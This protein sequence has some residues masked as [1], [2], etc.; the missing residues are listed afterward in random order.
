ML[1]MTSPAF[2]RGHFEAFDRMDRCLHVAGWMLNPTTP[3]ERFEAAIN[4]VLTASASPRL[5]A[6]V[7]AACASVPHAA[8]SGFRFVLPDVCNGDRV[9]VRGF[10]D[11]EVI[12]EL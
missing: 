1:L 12:A 2:T 5:R 10:R 7:Q 4:D 6:D 8:H 11:S 9:A 3:V